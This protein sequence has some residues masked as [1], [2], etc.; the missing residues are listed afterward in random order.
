MDTPTLN[1]DTRPRLLFIDYGRGVGGSASTMAT[2]LINLRREVVEP[3]AGFCQRASGA[4]VAE[5]EQMG[6]PVFRLGGGDPDALLSVVAQGVAW[7]RWRA[8]RPL[9]EALKTVYRVV[10]QYP[11]MTWMTMR[12]L[13]QERVQVLVLQN[14]L[15]YHVPAVVAAHLAHIP[16]I[17]RKAGGIGEGVWIRRLLTPWVS[18]FVAISMA[19]AE[20]QIHHAPRTRRLV[21]IHESVDTGKF[22]PRPEARQLRAQLGVPERAPLIGSL[23]RFQ[24]G[25]GQPEL[26]RAAEQVVRRRPDARFL[27]VG[28]EVDQRGGLR[29]RFE[30]L[31]CELGVSHCV[32][33]PGWRDDIP[34]LLAALDVFVHCP[35]T[36]LE[37]MGAANLEAMACGIPTVVSRNGG[38]PD[39][40]L[41][42]VTGFIVPPGDVDALAHAVLELIDDPARA[43]R[44]GALARRRAQIH[45]NAARSARRYEELILQ[46]AR[47]VAP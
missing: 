30:R 17:C 22:R 2:L 25:K 38:L 39:A 42:G 14:D 45:F 10:F 34:E 33:F 29:S 15:P 40:V 41:H 7:L 24:E 43:A 11:P 28:D 32:F 46:C 47:G 9:R 16:V 20:D 3:L 19:T 12:L 37:G 23:A 36:F 8:L 31:A 44:M 1:P 35:T 5:L 13:R 6:I 26:I 27:I 21:V 4:P 18:L